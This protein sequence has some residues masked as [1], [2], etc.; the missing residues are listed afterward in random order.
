MTG[1]LYEETL[2]TVVESE[3]VMRL[4][5][6]RARIEQGWC[7]GQY[8]RQMF[9]EDGQE[10]RQF[11]AL[12][13][14]G[15]RTGS[16]RK[17]QQSAVLLWAEQALARAL[18]TLDRDALSVAVWNDSVGRTQAEVLALYDL[19]IEMELKKEGA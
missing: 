9:G 18:F 8:W 11:C 3:V 1:F 19:A 15:Y 17:Q 12:G 6:G 2:P 4:R 10:Y 16:S 13:G 7:Q 5:E 14:L